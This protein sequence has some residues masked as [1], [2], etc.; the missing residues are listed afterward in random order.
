MSRA[1]IDKGHAAWI[2]AFKR[3]DA[4]ALGPLV[5][6]DMVC[7]PP[8]RE[9][10]T[11]PQGVVD[12]FAGVVKEARTVA[13]GISTREVIVAEDFAIERGAFTWKV[14]PTGGGPNVEDRGNFMAVWQKQPDG[15]WKIKRNIWNSTLPLPAAR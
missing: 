11:G 7:M 15:S 9:A 4:K 8:H 6:A 10:V 3:N 5:A 12:W 2:D 1:A 14:A 13:V